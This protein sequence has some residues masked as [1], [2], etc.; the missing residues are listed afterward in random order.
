MILAAGFDV[1]AGDN[2]VALPVADPLGEPVDEP[3]VA[4]LDLAMEVG[5]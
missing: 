2:S 1:W 5:S 4:W 3:V